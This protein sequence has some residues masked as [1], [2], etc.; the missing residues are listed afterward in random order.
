M[1]WTVS[2]PYYPLVPAAE[3]PLTLDLPAMLSSLSYLAVILDA[4]LVV[5]QLRQ[6]ANLLKVRTEELQ[7]EGRAN[8]RQVI[9]DKQRCPAN[10]IPTEELIRMRKSN[11]SFNCS[12]A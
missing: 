6:N 3:K 10:F 11:V 5:F 9:L 2:F 8:E 7:T 1:V 12:I 4:I